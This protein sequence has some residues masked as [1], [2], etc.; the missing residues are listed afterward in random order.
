MNCPKCKEVLVPSKVGLLCLGCGHAKKGVAAQAA[1][2]KH[3]A[4][5]KKAPKKEIDAKQKQEIE[6]PDDALLHEEGF[7]NL[8]EMKYPK[9]K[10]GTAIGVVIV[11]VVI[12]LYAAFA[13]YSHQRAI[14]DLKEIRNST[15]KAR[16]QLKGDD[17]LSAVATDIT[18]AGQQVTSPKNQLS[19][20]FTGTFFGKDYRGEGISQDGNLYFKLNGSEMPVLH[21]R[22][23]QFYYR[24]T[25]E[26]HSVKLDKS[27]FDEYCEV[28]DEADERTQPLALYRALKGVKA[29]PSPIVNPFSSLEGASA[30]HVS[31]KL[32]GDS[33]RNFISALMKSLPEGCSVNTIGLSPEDLT[34]LDA[35]YAI[36][37]G[38]EASRIKIDIKDKSTGLKLTGDVTLIEADAISAAVVPEQFFHLR[39]IGEQYNQILLRDAQRLKDAEALQ[40]ALAD[41]HKT[42]RRYPAALKE[43]APKFIQQLPKDPRNGQFYDYQTTNRRSGYV[44]TLVL[45]KPT[46]PPLRLTK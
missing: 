27:I 43:L 15:V 9:I 32:T 34:D 30:T 16:L 18:F 4:E 46:T 29:S 7:I 25:P 14:S 22:Q 17:L 12:G 26:W 28:R 42:H 19:G 39:Q 11:G 23:S 41:Y 36:W 38:K 6:T 37:T 8:P 20:Q 3:L 45:E 5:I 24:I 31:G 1:Y 10:R 40:T 44:L 21:Y 13:A 2:K 33:V 35:R